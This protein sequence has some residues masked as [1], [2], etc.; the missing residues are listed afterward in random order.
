MSDDIDYEVAD[1]AF[2]MEPGYFKRAL[3]S[4]QHQYIIPVEWEYIEAPT[5]PFPTGGSGIGYETTGNTFK[6]VTK[7]GCAC[8]KETDRV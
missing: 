1:K 4:H 3:D 6:R 7:L 5:Q 8:G 2:G